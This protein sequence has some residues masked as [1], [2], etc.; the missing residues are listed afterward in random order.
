M[1]SLVKI[2]FQSDFQNVNRKEN[3]ILVFWRLYIC[4]FN[5][6]YD[7]LRIILAWSL[8]CLIRI[9]VGLHFS[10]ILIEHY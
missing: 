5:F 9:Y 6:L 3:K 1:L 7:A 2:T 4:R 10:Q 8:F